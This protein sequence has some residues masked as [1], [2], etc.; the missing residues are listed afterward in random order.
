MGKNLKRRIVTYPVGVV[1][2]FVASDDL[3]ETLAK[4][5]QPRVT[6]ARIVALITDTI[7]QAACEPMT[8]IKGSQRQQTGITGDLTTR[9]ISSNDPVSVEEKESCGI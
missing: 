3:V 8:L 1:G 9:K 2:V 4:Q 7:C 6:N 5:R